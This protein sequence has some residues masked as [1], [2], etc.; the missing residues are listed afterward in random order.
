MFPWLHLGLSC[1]PAR[2]HQLEE[3]V[4]PDS[5]VGEIKTQHGGGAWVSLFK[6]TQKRHRAAQTGRAMG[7]FLFKTTLTKETWHRASQE[8]E[9]HTRTDT[10][11]HEKNQ[12]PPPPDT[13]SRAGALAPH[14]AIKKRNR[15][16]RKIRCSHLNLRADHQ[17]YLGNSLFP[18]GVNSEMLMQL[19]PM[20]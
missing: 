18:C 19:A 3:R 9:S 16:N 1:Q 13:V 6:T 8:Q 14:R 10:R 7:L 11:A 4:F 12:T 2:K 17:Y 20:G 15:G 5:N